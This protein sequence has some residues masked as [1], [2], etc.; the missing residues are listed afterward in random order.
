[1]AMPL[2][3]L[4]TLMTFTLVAQ[5]LS[6]SKAAAL[7]N[8]TQ[9]AISK[10][11]QQLEAQLGCT[12]FERA[13]GKIELSEAGRH[14]LP[15][16]VEALE[17]LQHATSTVM[18]ASHAK[19]QVAL[20]LPPSVASMWLIPRLSRFGATLPNIELAIKA[21][22]TTDTQNRFQGDIA[23]H[24]L[25]LS[26][27]DDD[28]QLLVREK[29]VLVVS[30]LLVNAPIKKI[31]DVVR[32]NAISHITRPQIWQ[33]FWHAQGVVPHS[34]SYGVGFEHFYMALEAVKHQ[35]GMALIP[36]FLVRDSLARGEV[37]NPLGLHYDSQYGYY[38]Y[39]VSYKRRLQAIEQVITWL[40]QEM[41]A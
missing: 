22:I 15:S 40:D 7:L 37:V 33:Q 13:G 30:P 41:G 19:P 17:N 16:V 28:A 6:F 31:E 25:P 5:T 32:F 10:Q 2:P 11:I 12:L 8:L 3:P 27:P 4:K 20:C 29:L 21:S 1:M 39:S 34:P 18:Q 38:L 14:Y 26:N 35:Q 9:S 23:V 24:C 36:D